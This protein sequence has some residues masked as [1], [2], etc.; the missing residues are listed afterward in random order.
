M[1]RSVK[2]MAWVALAAL[3]GGAAG[4]AETSGAASAAEC[5]SFPT[6]A[7]WGEIDHGKASRYVANKHD[8]DWSPYVKKWK[9]QLSKVETIWDGGG[10]IVFKKQDV[11]LEN[12]DLGIYV[13]KLRERVSIIEC[14][15][16]EDAIRV[17][18]AAEAADLASFSTAAGGPADTQ[19]AARVETD[20]LS[21]ARAALKSAEK[22]LRAGNWDRFGSAMQ[23][24]KKVLGE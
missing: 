5:P 19:V 2:M 17:A 13:E 15:A 7:L 12:E 14:L 16:E 20:Q 18:E 3:S 4:A 21:Q 24:L 23:R 8:G 6:A 22:A 9:R 1:I 11:K 10:T